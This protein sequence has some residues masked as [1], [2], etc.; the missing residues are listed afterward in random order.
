M[1]GRPA[2]G[3]DGRALLAQCDETKQA[4]EDQSQ[5]AGLRHRVPG[6]CFNRVYGAA[7]GEGLRRRRFAQEI[8]RKALANLQIKALQ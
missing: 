3:Y 4:Q 1:R 2:S 6:E 7:S 5:C 8:D